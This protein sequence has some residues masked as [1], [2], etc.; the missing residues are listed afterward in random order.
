MKDDRIAEGRPSFD[1]VAQAIGTSERW[2]IDGL[3]WFSAFIVPAPPVSQHR[4]RAQ[5]EAM[6]EAAE[7]LLTGLSAF[8][9]LPGGVRGP[10][11]VRIVRE[12][13]PRI[14]KWFPARQP[15]GRKRDEARQI[16]AGV[17][18]EA[19]ALVHGG[20]GAC[21]HSRTQGPRHRAL[22]NIVSTRLLDHL[23]G[24]GLQRFRECNRHRR[25]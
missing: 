21:P 20:T 24:S 1:D 5:Y 7:V 19:W 18:V 12:A 10:E 9:H 13:L 17:I 16:F 4:L 3:E 2:L 14:M 6:N 23:V 11:D 25:D 15:T 22:N 8:D